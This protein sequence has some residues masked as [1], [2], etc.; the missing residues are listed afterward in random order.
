MPNKRAPLYLRNAVYLQSNLI[1]KG[2]MNQKPSDHIPV[3]RNVAFVI[4]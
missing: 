2:Q 1:Y 4:I 3:S